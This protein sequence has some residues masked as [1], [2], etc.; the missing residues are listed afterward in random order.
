MKS[1][2]MIRAVAFDKHFPAESWEKA[3]RNFFDQLAKKYDHL[4]EIISLG[5][6][7]SYKREAVRDL[8]LKPED[9]KSVV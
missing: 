2:E 4:N 1:T 3:N 9:R 5:Q 8:K 6:Q 7:G